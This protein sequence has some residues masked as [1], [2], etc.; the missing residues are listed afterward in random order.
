MDNYHLVSE[1]EKQ[2]GEDNSIIKASMEDNERDRQIQ[3]DILNELK[4]INKKL[5]NIVKR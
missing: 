2:M 5:D 4:E 3:I 1:L